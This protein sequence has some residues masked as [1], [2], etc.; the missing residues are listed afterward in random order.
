MGQ[1]LARAARTPSP[2]K[3][4]QPNN[5][6]FAMADVMDEK[7]DNPVSD[8]DVAASDGG[9]GDGGGGGDDNDT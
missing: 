3:R 9:G 7:A 4:Q 5:T 6:Q 8:G 2:R 1:K